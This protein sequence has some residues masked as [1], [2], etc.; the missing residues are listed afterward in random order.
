MAGT[1]VE[2]GRRK[3]PYP[4]YHPAIE[5][6]QL[7]IVVRDLLLHHSAGKERVFWG[8]NGGILIVPTLMGSST[9]N[10]ESNHQHNKPGSRG[11][12][13]PATFLGHP[14]SH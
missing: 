11:G 10:W 1:R 14:L 9:L 6:G 2:G 12:G 7:G 4:G 13:D 3:A 5:A 8:G